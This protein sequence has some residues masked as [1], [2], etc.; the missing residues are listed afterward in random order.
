[1][2]YEEFKENV[3]REIGKKAVGADVSIED[4]RK[5]RREARTGLMIKY[6]DV[7]ICPIIYLEE[8]YGKMCME[9]DFHKIVREIW[10]KYLNYKVK[11]GISKDQIC[12]WELVKEK[13]CV[14]LI[15][16]Q[17]NKV[18]LEGMPYRRFLDLAVV[19]F[20]PIEIEGMDQAT[21]LVNNSCLEIWG[22]NREEMDKCALE[23]Y[24]NLYTP[25]VARLVEM[26]N[27]A[28]VNIPGAPQEESTYEGPNCMYVITN[29][30]FVFGAARML[31]P[32][33]LEELSD[34]F[35]SDLYILPSSVHELI[36]LPQ[37]EGEPDSL[38]EMVKSVNEY[39]V[40]PDEQ[41]SG[42]V[43]RYCRESGEIEIA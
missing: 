39:M 38:R 20:C 11:K 34:E 9:G 42:N 40:E 13:I 15:N 6:P 37:S 21:F 29:Q 18:M 19:Y 16:Y 5:G 41:L 12:R 32:K 31:F 7:N 23:N 30:E 17:K 1:M 24:Q 14:K 2:N 27:G 28:P 8:Y 33:E 43:Y 26:L 3:L 25:E 36:V 4:V 10:E 22:V 35:E